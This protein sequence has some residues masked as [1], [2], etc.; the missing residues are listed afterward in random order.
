MLAELGQGDRHHGDGKHRAP[1]AVQVGE[2]SGQL[3]PVVHAGH[4]HDLRVELYAPLAE[5]GELRD[6]GFGFRIAEQ[7]TAHHGIGGM[8]GH[9]EGRKPVLH[10][11]RQVPGLEIRERGEIAVA[12]REPVIVVPDV[13]CL[14][15]AERIPVHKAEVAVVGAAPDPGRLERHPHRQALGTLHVV[16]DLLTRR[17]PRPQHELVIGGEELPIEKI[18]EVS[19]VDREELRSGDETEG[20]AQRIGRHRLHA[21]HCWPPRGSRSL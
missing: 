6:D 9:V 2:G 16:L 18:L 3:R 8:H 12:K 20:G 14:A 21:N 5:P 4:E 15:Q 11:A 7:P 10:D 13:Q 1:D 19:V 17:Q